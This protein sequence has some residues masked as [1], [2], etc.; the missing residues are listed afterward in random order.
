MRSPEIYS[1][2]VLKCHRVSAQLGICEPLCKHTRA[3]RK[4]VNNTA[5]VEAEIQGIKMAPGVVEK[6]PM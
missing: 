5:R 4:R 2:P 6:F 1:S 3:N